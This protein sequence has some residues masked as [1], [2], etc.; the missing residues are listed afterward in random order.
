MDKNVVWS[1]GRSPSTTNFEGD[2]STTFPAPSSNASVL[3]TSTSGSDFVTGEVWSAVQN[4]FTKT[5]VILFFCFLVVYYC[6]YYI[7]GENSATA[8]DNSMSFSRGID[9]FLL[10]VILSATLTFYYQLPSAQ[11]QHLVSYILT[12]CQE[13]FDDPTT[14]ISLVL[15]IFLF[16]LTIF[17]C[18]VPMTPDTKPFTIAVIENKL[19]ISLLLVLFF[20]FCQFYFHI[21]LADMVFGTLESWWDHLPLHQRTYTPQDPSGNVPQDPSGNVP[22]DLSGNVPPKNEVF[23][24]SN[25]LYTYDDA[26]AVCTMFDARLASYDEVEK[27]YNDGGE[28]CNYGWSKDQMILFP[29]QKKT[30]DNLQTQPDHKNDCGRPGINGGYMENTAIKF[31]VNCFGVK[32]GASANDTASMLANKDVIYPK[33]GK[34]AILDAKVDYWKKH[35]DTLVKLNPFNRNQWKEY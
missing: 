13:F 15:I 4:I 17:V 8:S 7:L 2:A 14:L 3:Q 20:Q 34:D 5:N 16:Y 31:G 27:S 29:T 25:N 33:S 9:F 6:L 1:G 18:R 21:K 35:K 11:K 26:Q 32:P 19:F 24:V 23:N 12:S 22:Q 30:W 28:W 10:V